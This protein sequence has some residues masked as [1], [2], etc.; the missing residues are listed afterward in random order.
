MAKAKK[1]VFPVK[2]A[3]FVAVCLILLGGVAF[4][5]KTKGL[6]L[7][8]LPQQKPAEVV[9]KE[10]MKYTNEKLGVSL[11]YPSTWIVSETADYVNFQDVDGYYVF[12]VNFWDNPK[13]L[14]LTEYQ[15]YLD[16]TL[17]KPEGPAVRYIL[18][19]PKE[20]P[21]TE[22][23]VDNSKAYFT[24]KFLC[25]PYYCALYVVPRYK[26]IFGLGYMQTER[27]DQYIEDINKIISSFKFLTK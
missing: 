25:D 14:T 4:M 22:T 18:Y 24:D 27:L 12:N 26:R 11:E 1:N 16:T 20:R 8:K 17:P 3:V 10:W 15:K 9:K 5:L 7:S 13:N 21:V 19:D 23:K 6:H 2:L